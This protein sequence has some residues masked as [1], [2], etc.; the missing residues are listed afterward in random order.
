M[1]VFGTSEVAGRVRAGQMPGD[2]VAVT[3]YW[4][5]NDSLICCISISLQVSQ[6]NVQR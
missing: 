2:G 1:E 3:R 5:F 4:L 6:M